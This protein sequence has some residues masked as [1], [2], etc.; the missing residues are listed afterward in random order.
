MNITQADIIHARRELNQLAKHIGT[1]RNWQTRVCENPSLSQEFIST[2]DNIRHRLSM[3]SDTP[4]QATL[5]LDYDAIQHA[6]QKLARI[7]VSLDQ[8]LEPRA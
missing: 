6:I 7:W 2:L 1:H 4:S 5:E 3:R 8:Q